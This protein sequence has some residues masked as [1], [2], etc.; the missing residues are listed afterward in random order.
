MAWLFTGQGSQYAGMAQALYQTQ[1]VFRQTLQ[2]CAALLDDTLDRPLLEII[3]AK[4]G[5][6]EARLLN[7]TRYTQPALFALEIALYELWRSFG[8]EPDIVLGHSVGEYAAACVAGVFSLDDGL[9]LIARRGELMGQLPAGGA[10]AAVFT[11]ADMMTSALEG[12]ALSIAAHNG[13]HVVISGPAL[14][15]A[16]VLADLE[17]RGIRSQRLATSHAFHSALLEPILD[18]LEQTVATIDIQPAKRTLISNLSGEIL[19]SDQ[20]LDA[21]YWRRHAREPVQF[22]RSIETLAELGCTTLLEIGPQ[23]ILGTLALQCWPDARRPT[24]IA[25]LRRGIDEQRQL[26]EAAAQLY[27]SGARFDF[28]AWDAPWRRS[29]AGPADLSVPAP[30]LLAGSRTHRRAV[31]PPM[32][33]STSST[34]RCS[35]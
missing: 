1:P 9:R 26:C 10:M 13:T 16:T 3:F 25:S 24:L 2:R 21:A 33:C 4:A 19:A 17:Q 15:I 32:K 14:E 29:K 31:A 27:T 11:K 8:I 6:T 12:T 20:I 18:K 23:P 5:S 34:G 30:T 28:A 35:R 22:T 7:Q